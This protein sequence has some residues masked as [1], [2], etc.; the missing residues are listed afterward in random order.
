MLRSLEVDTMKAKPTLL[1]RVN[2]GSGKF[3]RVG[4]EIVRNAIK[5]PIKAL[6]RFFA[7]EDIVGFYMRY[8]LNGKRPIEPLGKDPVAAYA[9]FLQKERDVNRV[10][11]GFLPINPPESESKEDRSLQ[12]CASEFKA[13]LVTLGKKKATITAYTNSVDDFVTQFPTKTVD[14]ITKKDMLDHVNRLRATLKRRCHG[15]QQ[16][17]L[18][19]RLGYLST[20]F[21]SVGL[22]NPLPLREMKKP[23]KPRPTRYSEAIINLMLSVASENEKDLIHFFVNTG[24]RDEEVVYAVW[25]DIDFEA[26]SINVHAKPE[27]GW[28]PKD[29]EFREQDIVLDSRFIKKMQARRERGHTSDLIFQNEK[30]KPNH[31]FLTIIKKVANRAGIKDKRI[32]LHAFRRTFCN[33]VAKEYGIEQARVWLGHS[34]IQTTQRYLACEEMTTEESRRKVKAMFSG[35]GD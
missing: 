5:M 32:T 16:R 17:T 15:D 25:S 33:I 19:N 28:S 8:S 6:G 3:P 18:R 12:T 34:D 14:E 9:Q 1:A 23:M 7:K 10:K 13:S 26:G 24:F 31:R 30:G 2:D 21:L 20:F 27:Y 29:S 11:G 35:I 22:K 4:V